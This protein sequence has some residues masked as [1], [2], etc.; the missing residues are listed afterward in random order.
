MLLINLILVVAAT[1]I[2]L[3]SLLHILT[4]PMNAIL[5]VFQ[6]YHL[7]AVSD[8]RRSSPAIIVSE[9]GAMHCMLLKRR[10]IYRYPAIIPIYVSLAY[11]LE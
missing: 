6:S 5:V 1:P 2:P 10:I 4:S 7:L 9:Q 3:L 8:G 11:G